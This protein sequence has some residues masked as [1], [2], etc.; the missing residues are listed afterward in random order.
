MAGID[1]ITS[2][3]FS[4]AA[5]ILGAATKA[6][7]VKWLGDQFQKNPEKAIALTTVASIVVKDGVGCYK[8]V[9]QSLNNERIPEKQ[10]SFVA[11]L[12]LTNGVLMIAAQIAMFFA[13]RKFSEP[14]FNKLFKKSFN[15]KN[16]KDIATRIR[17]LQRESGKTPSRKLTIDKEY[18][19]VRKDALDVFKFVADIAAATIIGKRVIVPFIATPLASKVQGKMQASM[20]KDDDKLTPSEKI[21]GE[22]K[23]ELDEAAGID[24]DA[25]EIDNDKHE[26][27]DDD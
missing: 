16:A 27:K 25:H 21:A 18:Q 22:L 24:D 11:A 14:I 17:M 4:G 6:K 9:T 26:E 12:D 1:K 10:R 19:K 3:F 20:H 13:M 23:E 7:P 15:E 5:S 8:Y 2:G